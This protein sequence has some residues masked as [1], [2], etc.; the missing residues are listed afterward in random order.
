MSF[1]L[2]VACFVIACFA[3]VPSKLC[4]TH[5]L[6]QEAKN[7]L[8][9]IAGIQEYKWFSQVH[10][11]DT[12]YFIQ[13]SWWQN[14]SAALWEKEYLARVA[15]N[16]STYVTE[17]IKLQTMFKHVGDELNMFE[18]SCNKLNCSMATRL[19]SLA[20][21]LLSLNATLANRQHIADQVNLLLSGDGA[22]TQGF[23]FHSRYSRA[24]RIATELC[25]IVFDPLPLNARLL[26]KRL[27]AAKG[28]IGDIDSTTKTAYSD[29]VL[30]IREF[31]KPDPSRIV[32]VTLIDAYLV[33]V[34][35][36][37]GLKDS[38][39]IVHVCIAACDDDNSMS[40]LIQKFTS[41]RS[42][43]GD[44]T[45]LFRLHVNE[46]DQFYPPVNTSDFRLPAL[47]IIRAGSK[48][49]PEVVQP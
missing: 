37:F 26:R 30:A 43:E 10:L 44:L 46:S 39:V 2:I 1:T 9:G 47:I 29:L 11:L 21:A 36:K 32:P 12:P 8:D 42:G 45:T 25:T 28:R 38:D 19:N 34:A 14:A 24:I 18:K 17:D 20:D 40:M 27:L 4:A 6:C 31:T 22:L 48:A 13:E 3:A 16:I 5:W 35:E 41:R 15:R 7:E 33:K 49:L 23:P